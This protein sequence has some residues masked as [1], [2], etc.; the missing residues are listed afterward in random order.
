MLLSAKF[1]SAALGALF[2]V[3]ALC[4]V[5]EPRVAEAVSGAPQAALEVAGDTATVNLTIKGM[6]CGSC[7]TTASIVLRRVPG[8]YKAQVSFASASAAVS[9]D[10]AKTSPDVFIG[11]LRKMTGYEASV[12]KPADESR[13]KP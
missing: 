3:D 12:I 13:P 7:A 11:Q 5:C 1:V 4:G 8:V 2:G 6:T 10:P 9:Y